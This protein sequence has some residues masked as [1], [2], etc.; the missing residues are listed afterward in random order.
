MLP[1]IYKFWLFTGTS[2][3]VLAEQCFQLCHSLPFTFFGSHK[4]FHGCFAFLPKI[5]IH[6]F[7]NRSFKAF[8]MQIYYFILKPAMI[9]GGKVLYPY[10]LPPCACRTMAVRLIIIQCLY[11]N[12]HYSQNKS[13]WVPLLRNS[14]V[15]FSSFCSHSINQSGVM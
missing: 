13:L 12:L 1:N 8:R 9:S 7:H 15:N 14:K 5:I 2:H 3:I 10:T 4:T 6:Y 11:M